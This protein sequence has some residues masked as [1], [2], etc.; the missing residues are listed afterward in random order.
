MVDL[1]GLIHRPVLL[2]EVVGLLIT[3]KRGVYV[4]ATTGTGGHSIV[5]LEHLDSQGR[6]ISLDRDDQALE[7]AKNR[8]KDPRQTFVKAS[9]S[10]LTERLQSLGINSIDGVLFDLGLSMLQLKDQ[11]RGFSFNSKHRLDMRM[12]REQQL[13]AYQVV[14]NYSEEELARIIYQ[15]GQ[16]RASKKIAKAIVQSRGNKPIETC[17]E[18]ASVVSKVVGHHGKIHPATKTFQAIR[19]EVNREIDELKTG[20]RSALQCLKFGGRLCVISYH[21]LEDREVKQ[22]FR[23]SAEENQVRL[24]TKKPLVPSRQEI[25]NNTSARSA[26]LRACERIY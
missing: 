17:A 26:R 15:Y 24:I 6:L 7:V 14:N 18:L 21:S 1:E 23:L 10:E 16:E 22:F 13:D 2:E 9:F 5:I 4:D 20:L 3:N 19:I 11:A 12:D 8:S 25:L